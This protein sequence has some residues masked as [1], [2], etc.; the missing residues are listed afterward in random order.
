MVSSQD[1]LDF[2]LR[3]CDVY[4]HPAANAVRAAFPQDGAGTG[5]KEGYAAA[6]AEWNAALIRRT[7]ALP[8]VA[9]LHVMPITKAARQM[10]VRML[11]DGTLP[12]V[13]AA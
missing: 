9:G 13:T 8:G 2:W 7:L 11:E 10:T 1:N 12:A 6:V 3:L 4:G 5:G